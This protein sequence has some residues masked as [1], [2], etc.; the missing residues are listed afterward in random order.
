MKKCED[1]GYLVNNIESEELKLRILESLQYHIKEAN[2]YKVLSRLFSYI[3]IILPAASTFVSYVIAKEQIENRMI[4]IIPVITA[5]ITVFS[6]IN[7]FGRYDEKKTCYREIAEKIKHVL[8][9]FQ[10]KYIQLELDKEGKYNKA[11]YNILISD[12]IDE[13]E[14]IIMDGNIKLLKVDENSGKK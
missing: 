14:N 6:G 9:S 10:V 12:M 4:Y 5:M 7:A 1:Y 2:K 3:S 11:E 13:I 8:V